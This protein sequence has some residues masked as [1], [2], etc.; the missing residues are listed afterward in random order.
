MVFATTCFEQNEYGSI[1]VEPCYTYGINHKQ[2]VT[3]TPNVTKTAN[4]TLNFPEKVTQGNIYLWKNI[5]KEINNGF[6]KDLLT[7]EKIITIRNIYK[8]EATTEDCIYEEPNIF[9]RKLWYNIDGENETRIICFSSYNQLNTTDANFT[10]KEYLYNINKESVTNYVWK[11]INPPVT[12]FEYAGKHLYTFLNHN[13]IKDKPIKL[14][15]DYRTEKGLT[16]KWDAIFWTGNYFSNTKWIVLDPEYE[17][18]DFGW[19]NTSDFDSGFKDNITTDSNRYNQTENTLEL[20]F[21]YAEKDDDLK[22]YYRFENDATDETGL[23]HGD[24]DGT[25]PTYQAIGYFDGCYDFDGGDDHIESLNT[26]GA[27]DSDSHSMAFWFNSDNVATNGLRHWDF[28]VTGKG[29]LVAT[30]TGSKM[31]F[32]HRHAGGYDLL[33]TS[34]TF[35]TSTWYNVIISYDSSTDIAR[36][37]VDGLEKAVDVGGF[38]EAVNVGAT[39]TN[40]IAERNAEAGGVVNYNG[41][42]DE[43]KYYSRALT[44]DE[45]VALYNGGDKYKAHGTWNSTNITVPVNNKISNISIEF[46]SVTSDTT[47]SSVHIINASDNELIANFTNPL[48]SGVNITLFD[49]NFSDGS[50]NLTENG[51]FKIQV[52]LNG[53]YTHTPSIK[54]IYGYYENVST[55]PPPT[56]DLN[57]TINNCYNS[58]HEYLGIVKEVDGVNTTI[59]QNF[60][61]CSYGCSNMCNDP[62][63]E[64]SYLGLIISVL[65]GIVGML[66]YLAY[67]LKVPALKMLFIIIGGYL[68]FTVFGIFGLIL[69]VYTNNF[70]L[71]EVMLTYGL[72][73]N[74]VIYFVIAL[75]ITKITFDTLKGVVK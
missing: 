68:I 40:T 35:S 56:T 63:P 11:L 9:K 6:I 57:Y 43:M 7:T 47:I 49:A 4:L 70:L 34:N 51:N 67:I 48:T 25:S 69:N 27:Y 13:F 36:F 22:R 26:D 60:T 58:T 2:Y 53:N 8:N 44:P 28:A 52:V 73:F 74:Y 37:Y 30:Y 59:S 54:Q 50:L 1:S 66:I 32:W 3:I 23:A 14:L 55:P 39:L 19:G 20:D 45:M 10:I 12:Y 17:T 18:A 72:V 16:G 5:T 41:R 15:F 65:L 42:L 31:R 71:A 24:F 64:I 33:T 46:D 29:W 61:L 21:P 62:S 75:I 38:F